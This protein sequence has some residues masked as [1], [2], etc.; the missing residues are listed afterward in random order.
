MSEATFRAGTGPAREPRRLDCLC[1][2]ARATETA[3]SDA[4]CQTSRPMQHGLRSIN[5]HDEPVSGN[6]H[7]SASN[8]LIIDEHPCRLSERLRTALALPEYQVQVAISS[9]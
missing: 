4:M 1:A 2:T 9:P 8:V 6:S 5:A 3:M 7:A